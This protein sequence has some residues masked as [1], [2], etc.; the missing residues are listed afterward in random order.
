[1]LAIIN[2]NHKKVVAAVEEELVKAQLKI[3]RQRN[4]QAEDHEQRD[5]EDG[6]EDDVHDDIDVDIDDAAEYDDDENNDGDSRGRSVP[7]DITI[8]ED[9]EVTP[10]QEGTCY[11]GEESSDE[12]AHLPRRSKR[13]KMPKNM[14][15]WTLTKPLKRRKK[16]KDDKDKFFE[17]I[18]RMS[19][20]D[21]GNK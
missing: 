8:V 6:Q 7:L 3:E 1:M 12:E 5:K 2:E 15:P 18:S 21:E 10:N 16:A 19:K 9:I 11:D 4:Q 17:L 14:S 20:K 13:P